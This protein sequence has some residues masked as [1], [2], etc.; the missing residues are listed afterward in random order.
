MA[1]KTSVASFDIRETPCW[2]LIEKAPWRFFA[3][4]F[5]FIGIP[6]FFF[7]YIGTLFGVRKEVGTSLIKSPQAMDRFVVVTLN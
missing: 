7:F 2:V 4:V 3:F 1:K 5:V 6:S